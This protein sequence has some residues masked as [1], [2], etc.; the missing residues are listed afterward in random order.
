MEIAVSLDCGL[1]GISEGVAAGESLDLFSL[2]SFPPVCFIMHLLMGFVQQFFLCKEAD[3]L[4][5][6]YMSHSTD[7]TY[8]NQEMSER[9]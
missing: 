4:C 9:P 3:E 2:A 6:F 5:Y 8:F 1:M 7:L